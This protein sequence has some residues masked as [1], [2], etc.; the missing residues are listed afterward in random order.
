MIKEG[1][2]QSQLAE[3]SGIVRQRICDYLANRRRITVEASLKL[4]KA[5][6]IDIEGFFY[7][8]QANHDIYTY[9][10]EQAINNHPNLKHY[11]KAVFWDTDIDTLDWDKNRQ[12]IIRRVFEYGGEEEI[13]E[14]IC[15]YGKDV[16]KEILSDIADERKAENR[17]ENIKMYL[18]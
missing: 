3:R 11:R 12:W 8:I 15:F 17:S 2:S 14:T 13:L 9:L 18:N 6:R 1:I 16:V 5:L 7:R 10:K 4:E